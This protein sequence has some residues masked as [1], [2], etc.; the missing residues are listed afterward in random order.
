LGRPEV[1]V[2]VAAASVKRGD[3]SATGTA[4]M[5]VPSATGPTDAVLCESASDALTAGFPK[6]AVQSV[7]DVLFEGAPAVV[8]A[9][10]EVAP[11]S[12]VAADSAI[13]EAAFNKMPVASY[14][15]GQVLIPGVVSPDAHDTL[16]EFAGDTG[17]TA[18]LDGEADSS[19]NDLV[20]YA[21][22]QKA[23]SGARRTGL[24][25][26]WITANA[27]AGTTRQVP[28]SIV[29]A[30]LAARMDARKGHAGAMPAGTQNFGD[31]GRS[32]LAIGTTIDFTDDDRTALAAAGVSPII[33]RRDGNFY[34]WDWL[35]ISEDQRWNQLNFGRIAMEIGYALGELFEQFLFRNIDGT[36]GLFNEME[37]V[38]D[39]YFL[40]LYN[41][42]ALY[43]SEPR[44]AYTIDIAGQTT[45]AMIAT[46]T[47]KCA[48]ECVPAPGL[49]KIE[50]DVLLQPAGASLS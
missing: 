15:I 24:I 49:R 35:S 36:G 29:A 40:N 23:K 25:G 34:L 8:L 10:A 7:A 21:Q 6:E 39:S 45:P 31:A 42:G 46:G 37:A 9:R 4:F 12:A 27:P 26:G 41:G 18:L 47:V 50:F 1:V 30:G 20:N 16:V 22:A 44:K 14:G 33:P 17:R 48:V 32:R 11:E 28:G 5:V 38:A 13:W 2:N 3:P 43:G 19:V